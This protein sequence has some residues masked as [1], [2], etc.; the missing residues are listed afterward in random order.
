M[1]WL[2]L[3]SIKNESDEIKFLNVRPQANNKAF[4]DLIK[5]I[6]YVLQA[7]GSDK[8]YFTV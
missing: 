8:N 5:R 7:Q 3:S 2:L 1:E 4:Y 6:F